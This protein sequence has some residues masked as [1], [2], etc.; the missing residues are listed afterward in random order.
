[1]ARSTGH[2]ATTAAAGTTAA[3]AEAATATAA[4]TSFMAGALFR[5]RI[6]KWLALVRCHRSWTRSTLADSRPDTGALMRPRLHAFPRPEARAA[7]PIDGYAFNRDEERAAALGIPDF[8]R[9]NRCS[10]TTCRSGPAVIPRRLAFGA[11]VRGATSRCRGRS[12]EQQFR[13]RTSP[14]SHRGTCRRSG[15]CRHP[16]AAPSSVLA[17]ILIRRAPAASPQSA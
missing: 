5:C 15:R 14:P 9:R 13:L 3:A 8:L 4:A 10:P 2:M 11:V 17:T 6:C 1:M 7:R 16:V 12:R